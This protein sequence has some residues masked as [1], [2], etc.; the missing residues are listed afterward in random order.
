[1]AKV[2]KDWTGGAQASTRLYFEGKLPVA[3][4]KELGWPGKNLF[5]S[6]LYAAV[7]AVVRMMKHEDVPDEFKISDSDLCRCHSNVLYTIT[8]KKFIVRFGVL[9]LVVCDVAP[10][11]S[12]EDKAVFD[13]L[14][15]ERKRA[16]RYPDFNP[17]FEY[18]KTPAKEIPAAK[19]ITADTT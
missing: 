11:Q 17:I 3:D 15:A 13:A 6:A 2:Y 9:D 8:A 10:P 1:M 18:A 4:R 14:L 12:D 16:F 7:G 5:G 19:D